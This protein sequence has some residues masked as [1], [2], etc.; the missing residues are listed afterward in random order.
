MTKTLFLFFFKRI[1]CKKKVF[2]KCN[3][4]SSKLYHENTIP[5]EFCHKSN[6]FF[7]ITYRK[8]LE[9]SIDHKNFMDF[10]PIRSCFEIP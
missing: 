10:D 6:A 9:K 4:F 5:I 2:E 1:Y 3:S 7:K 8:V